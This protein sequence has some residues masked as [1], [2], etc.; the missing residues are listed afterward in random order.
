MAHPR[1]YAF[2]PRL[3][4]A[5]ISLALI[6]YMGYLLRGL[7]QS[8]RELQRSAE[9]RILLDADKRATALGYFFSER[10]NDLVDLMDNRE[11]L[12]YFENEALGM[13]MEYGLGASLDGATSAIQA[14]R[15]KKRLRG[16]EIYRR[17]VFLDSRGHKLLDVHGPELRPQKHEEVAWR[18]YSSPK[19]V[20]FL[21]GP[22][23]SLVLVAPYRFKGV[24]RG[25]LLAWLPTLP[26]YQH[27]VG[28]ETGQRGQISLVFGTQWLQRA[29]GATL[30]DPQLADLSTARPGE[31]RRVALG[32]EEQP[33]HL[34]CRVAIPDLPMS[35]VIQFPGTKAD[36]ISPGAL[37]GMAASLGL[38]ILLGAFALF[39]EETHNRVLNA[40]L[41]ES[42]R[43]EHARA[44]Q[45]RLLDS[46]RTAA[47]A[48]SRAKSEF[49]ASM[50]HEIRTPMNGIIGMTGLALETQLTADQ[51][52]YMENV[53]IS[54]DGLLGIINDLLDFSKIEAGKVE[55]EQIP[56]RLRG[57]IDETFKSLA[58]RAHEKGLELITDLPA[59]IPDA[60]V[61]DPGRIRQILMNLLG[62]AV[63]F[64]AQGEISLK[65]TISRHLGSSLELHFQVSDTGIGITPEARD[66]IFQP[67][68]QAEGSHARRFGGTG[69]GLT[70]TRQLVD[71]MG[72]R[73]WV[74][75]EPGQGSVFHVLLPLQPA[76]AGPPL[77]LAKFEALAGRTVLLVDDNPSLRRILAR[78]LG[79]WGLL[80]QESDSQAQTLAIFAEAPPDLVLIDLQVPGENMWDLAARLRANTAWKNTR[81]ILMPSVGIPGDLAL[82]RDLKVDGYLS[83]PWSLDDLTGV[84]RTVLSPREGEGE[85]PPVVTRYLLREGQRVLRILLAE[86]NRVNQKL[87][88]RLL[89]REGHSVV[90][91]TDGREAVA[92]WQ[93]EAFDLVL[94]DVQMPE[95]DGLQATRRIR[96]LEAGSSGHTPI[97]AMTANAMKGDEEACLEAGMDA[98]LSKPIQRDRFSALLERMVQ[99]DLPRP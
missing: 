76:P 63:K 91:A 23:G 37:I 86:D 10:V 1:R 69:L 58:I 64:T 90:L 60:F 56:F 39:R 25:S 19:E 26:I 35:L 18:T 42:R 67:F 95:M 16:Q 93:K 78:D 70:I 11:L 38:L 80:V 62:N 53:R 9:A 92:L 52:E 97:V 8:R 75:S 34:V 65:A 29:R 14:F 96:E 88:T 79:Q 74:E 68:V 87:A 54:A 66:S 99:G 73:I 44:E 31:L 7:Y 36:E 27:F 41:E 82:C 4:L 85:A 2:A 72:G 20:R 32:Q 71:L 49:L 24:L 13:S 5:L 12:A 17:V 48:A 89:E 47:E 28:E 21:A 33:T 45:N 15:D 3:G 98:Y 57:A 6:A 51:R 59:E 61:G 46:A 40:R 81:I 22:D 77:E 43:L 83:K 94:M 55:L 84:V 30:S 50:S